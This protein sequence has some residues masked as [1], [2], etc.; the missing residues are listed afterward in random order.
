MQVETSQ[1]SA[2]SQPED[3]GLNQKREKPLE[4]MIFV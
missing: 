2:M 1:S 3:L 4:E